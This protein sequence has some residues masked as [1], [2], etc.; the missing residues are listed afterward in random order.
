[1]GVTMPVEK[2]LT[3]DIS[4]EI[5]TM[6]LPPWD[7]TTA[8]DSSDRLDK[9]ILSQWPD[10]HEFTLLDGR[11]VTASDVKAD[12]SLF[13]EVAKAIHAIQMQGAT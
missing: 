5:N 12:R 3:S 10:D 13:R 8:S 4:E 9:M 6:D 2:S 11:T 1:M 7:E